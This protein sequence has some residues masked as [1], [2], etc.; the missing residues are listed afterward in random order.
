MLPVQPDALELGDVSRHVE[1]GRGIEGI[2]ATGEGYFN[3]VV[4]LM[5]AAPR[6]EAGV[7]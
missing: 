1:E 7:A 4:E 5:S 6:A 2:V 3:P